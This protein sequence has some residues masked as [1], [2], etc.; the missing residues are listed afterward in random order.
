MKRDNLTTIIFLLKKRDLFSF[1]EE[2]SIYP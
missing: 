2:V 1:C